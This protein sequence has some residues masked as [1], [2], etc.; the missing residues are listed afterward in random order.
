VLSFLTLGLIQPSFGDG[1]VY[2]PFPV[3]LKGYSGDCTNS[4]SYSGQIARH[5]LH[6][7]LKSLVKS[8][9]LSEMMAYYK[10]SD[11]NKKIHAPA[12]K[13][14]FIIKQ[15]FV[16]TISNGKN[17]SGKTY[18][19]IINGWPGE[20]T[21][22]EVLESMITKAAS[23]GGADVSVGY[24]YT[25][26][27]SKFAMG[28]VFYNQ[29]VD[30]YLDE[31]LAADTKPNSKPYKD[32]AC[33]TGKEHVWDEAFGYWGAAAHSL[34]LTAEQNYNV[35]KKKDMV[36]ADYDGDGKVDLKSEYVFAHAYYASSFDKSAN[37]NYFN[38]ITQAYLD[39]RKLITEANGEDLTDMERARLVAY[40]DTIST[41]WEKVIAEA[42]FKYAGETYETLVKLDTASAEDLP[43]LF[44]KYMKYWG[45]LKGFALALQTGKSNLGE[46][47]VKLNRMVGMGPMLMDETQVVGMDADGNYVMGKNYSW[48]QNKLHMLKVQKLMVDVFGVTAKSHD[49]LGNMSDLAASLGSSES[50]E[51]D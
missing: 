24:D 32:G 8:G 19:G 15:G 10:G 42:V 3:T 51:N 33:Y 41:N 11:K 40:A 21:G 9:D 35:A 26:L 20:M 28:A 38:T 18:K 12:S 4:V 49:Q 47:A 22:P 16:N 34:H 25:Q 13:G 14:D 43:N 23:T 46:T 1:H 2:G 37:T 50:A 39:G 44:G 6:D 48:N 30:N 31:K 36:S 17:L 5:V 29:A 27:I 45:E 7:S